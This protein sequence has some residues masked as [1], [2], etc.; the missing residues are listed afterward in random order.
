[1]SHGSGSDPDED[2][3]CCASVQFWDKFL[4]VSCPFVLLT[5]IFSQAFL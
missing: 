5:V 3:V 1:M 2:E 4:A